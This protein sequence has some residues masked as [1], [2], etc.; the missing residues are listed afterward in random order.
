MGIKVG[1]CGA[2]GGFIT[3]FIPLFQAHPDVDDVYIA[4]LMAEPLAEQ[5]SKFGVKK[6]FASLDELCESDC[7]HDAGGTR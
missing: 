1:I 4:D 6:T 7:D 5:A 2:A 3:S